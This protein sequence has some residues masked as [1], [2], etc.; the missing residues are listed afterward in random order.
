MNNRY[1]EI[2]SWQK[3]PLYNLQN[4][5]CEACE[6]CEAFNANVSM[7][8]NYDLNDKRRKWNTPE[9]QKQCGKLNDY[10]NKGECDKDE[11]PTYA[12][13]LSTLSTIMFD[14]IGAMA[15]VD[16]KRTSTNSIR[17][18]VIHCFLVDFSLWLLR[19]FGSQLAFI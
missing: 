11:P 6:P 13:D 3:T 7:K 5:R 18:D 8:K 16:S 19:Y 10:Y 14:I 1:S 12:S 9:K 15:Y 2:R 17:F 4:R